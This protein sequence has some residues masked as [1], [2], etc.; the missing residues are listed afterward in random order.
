MIAAA[1]RRVPLFAQIIIACCCTIANVVV[2]G[3]NIA[4]TTTTST[5]ATIATTVAGTVVIGIAGIGTITACQLLLKMLIVDI[6][7]AM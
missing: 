6:V 1:G 2:G 7:I 4:A 3:G 5:T